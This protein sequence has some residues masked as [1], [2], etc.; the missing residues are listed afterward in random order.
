MGWIGRGS[1]AGR[2]SAH[3][4]ESG[5][6][7]TSDVCDQRRTGYNEGTDWMLRD[8]CGRRMT[9]PLELPLHDTPKAQ[10][11]LKSHRYNDVNADVMEK[12]LLHSVNTI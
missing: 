8:R 4:R 7:S 5:S 11:R 1:A 12:V 10:N 9:T 6:K 2:S 3:P